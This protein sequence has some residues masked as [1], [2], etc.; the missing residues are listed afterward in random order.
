MC[1][2]RPASTPSAVADEHGEAMLMVQHTDRLTGDD[3][4][5]GRHAEGGGDPRAV[6]DG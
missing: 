3:E 1:W 6:E 2:C 5:Q 4:V